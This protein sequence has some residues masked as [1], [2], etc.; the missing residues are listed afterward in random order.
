MLSIF[1]A[2]VAAASPAPA[3]EPQAVQGV[4][5]TVSRPVVGDLK[6]GVQAYRSEFFTAVRPGTAFD[7]VQWLPGFTM[8]ETRDMR[9]LGGAVGNV[10]IDGQPPTSKNDTL[11]TVLRRI[12]AA[13]VERVDI[14][15]GGAPGIDM[16][17]RSVIANVVLKKTGAPKGQIQAQGFVL[18]GGRFFPELQATTNRRFG[19]RTL[20]GALTLAR[21]PLNQD[22]GM[23]TGQLVR[24]NGDGTTAFVAD[25]RIKGVQKFANGS[26]AYQFPWAGGKLRVNAS[27]LYSQVPVT[28]RADQQGAPA[29][30]S[31]DFVDTFKQGELGGRYER[32]FGRTT[33]ESQ[34]LQRLNGHSQQNATFRP[35]VVADLDERD[36]LSESVAR[37]TLRFAKSPKLTFEGSAEGAYN[38]QNT[39]SLFRNQGVVTAI[40]AQNLSVSEWRGELG[41]L[42]TYKP[43][44]EF[45]MTAATRLE[46]S[47]LTA[48]GDFLVRRDLT[49][50]KPRLVLAWTPDKK[51]QIRLRGEHEVNQ[52]GFGN[53]VSVIEP[54]TGQPRAGNPDLRPRRAWVG[55]AVLE[56]QLWTGASFVLTARHSALRDVTDQRP[57]AA[58]GGAT[59]IGNIGDGRQTELAATVTLPLKRLGLEG[60]NLKATGTRRWSEVTDPTTGERRRLTGQSAFVGDAHFSHDLPRLKLTWGVDVLYQGPSVLYRPANL[61]RIGDLLRVSAFVEYRLR[62]DLN[63]RVEGMNLADVS[64]SF[65]VENYAGLRGQSP[66]VYVDARKLAYG[67]YLF[68]RV[69]KTL[70]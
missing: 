7:M 46:T 59:A 44:G 9:G 26:G 35:P 34:V 69:R 30:Y 70:S 31:I 62:P 28:E 25:S 18:A 24:T 32:K 6:E 11:Q 60:M 50:L 61:Q 55:E 27:A 68:V 10:L 17:G 36:T 67:P 57:L 20:E 8:E 21:R 22:N 29:V 4:E 54:I 3:T 48:D 14:I 42:V 15:V 39:S 43:N 66:L 13:Q 45:S 63:L 33:W 56:R 51:T 5:I 37:T 49:Y 19:E 41:G 23:G 12:P 53:F 47:N 16:R 58:F 1:A 52:I 2:A 38:R 64:Q 40:P 65:V